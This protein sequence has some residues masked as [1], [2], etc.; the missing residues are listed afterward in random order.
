MAFLEV[1][2]ID[3]RFGNFLA[4]DKVSLQAERNSV[5]VICGPSG[6]GKSTLIR[7]INRLAGDLAAGSIRVDGHDVHQ[8]APAD[9]YRDVGMVFQRFNLFAHLSVLENIMIAQTTVLKMSK[10]EAREHAMVLLERVGL[11]HKAEALPQRLSGGQQ[12]RVAICR[13]L[14]MKPKL[15]L[16]DEPTSALDP[17][18][19]E[20]VLQVMLELAGSGMTMVVVTHEMGF[21]RQVSDRIVFMEGGRI[22]EESAPDAF[23]DN[24]QQARTQQF[25]Q[26]LIPA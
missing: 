6:S 11:A 8:I 21:A 12:Q 1:D 2:A 13:A 22:I 16:F 26:K 24:P 10:Y 23:F 20:E 7:C 18:M 3:K 15:M 9:L 14:A 5:T 19:V 4:L 25:L 17:E